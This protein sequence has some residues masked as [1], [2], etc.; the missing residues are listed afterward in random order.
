MKEMADFCPEAAEVERRLVAEADGMK[1]A[2]ETT[3]IFEWKFVRILIFFSRVWNDASILSLDE[4]EIELES[5]LAFLPA[6]A[7]KEAESRARGYTRD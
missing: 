2:E 5:D 7:R 1:E 6:G 4:E 3:A